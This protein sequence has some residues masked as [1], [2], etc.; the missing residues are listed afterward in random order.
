MPATDKMS[1]VKDVMP[2][3]AARNS[4]HDAQHQTMPTSNIAPPPADKIIYV[5]QALAPLHL[6]RSAAD[7]HCSLT[8]FPPGRI[9]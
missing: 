1:P 2:A 3:T 4:C 6:D 7:P 9:L 8:H 5:V